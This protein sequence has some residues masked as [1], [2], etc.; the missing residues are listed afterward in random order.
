MLLKDRLLEVSLL[1]FA[2]CVPNS[3]V[4]TSP[5]VLEGAEILA[6]ETQEKIGTSILPSFSFPSYSFLPIHLFPIHNMFSFKQASSHPVSPLLHSERTLLWDISNQASTRKAQKS[7]LSY[8][9]NRG[10]ESF[11]PCPSY[12][13]ST[14]GERLPLDRYGSW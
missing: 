8:V 14:G 9:D 13:Q 6:P 12:K 7:L 4:S 5:A 3:N 10:R 2:P 11:R 1:T